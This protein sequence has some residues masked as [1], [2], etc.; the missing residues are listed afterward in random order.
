[1]L[2]DNIASLYFLLARLF[3]NICLRIKYLT[4][5]YDNVMFNVNNACVY[6]NLCKYVGNI[7]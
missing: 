2:R 6:N 7:S 3:M 5:I 4:L 1:M